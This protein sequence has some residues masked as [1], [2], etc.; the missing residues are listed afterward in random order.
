MARPRLELH[1]KFCEILGSRNCYYRPP[2]KFKMKYPCIR[3]ERS[4]IEDRRADNTAYLTMNRYTVTVVDPDPDSKIPEKVLALPYCS[5][6]REYA[7]EGLNHF[8]FTIY[9]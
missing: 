7:L 1:E 9:H 6:D 3:Y 2:V 5:S 8:V 4:A